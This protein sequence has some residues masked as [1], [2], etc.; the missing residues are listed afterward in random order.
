MFVAVVPAQ[1]A[2]KAIEELLGGDFVDR[3]MKIQRSESEVYVPLSSTVLPG[4]LVERY[5]IR[6]EEWDDRRRVVRKDPFEEICGTLEQQGLDGALIEL[7]PDRWEMHGDV[8][9]LKLHDALLGDRGR[10]AKVYADVL[11]ARTVLRDKVTIRG[12]ERVPEMELLLGESTE[13]IHC[14]NGILY[15]L[16]AARIMFSSGNIE[17]RMR[18][19][20]IECEGETVVDMFAGIGYL[21]LPMAVHG[22]PRT[23]FACEI[24]E[25]S[26][27][28]LVKNIALNHV[29]NIVM[30]VLGDNR[31]FDL[32]GKADRIIMGYLRDTYSFLPKAL[33][34][35]RSGG[36][37]HYHENYP[38]ALLPDGPAERL[39]STAGEAWNVEVIGQRVVKTFAPGVSHVV[40]DA[41]FTSSGLC[42][43][44]C[45][46]S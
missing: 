33:E 32:P 39:R 25:L 21:S 7:L 41:R 37:I 4:S 2:G 16:D 46:R 31:D 9:V 3:G 28:Y 13:G 26:Y 43:P 5:R 19:A 42:R 20:S 36:M 27:G 24:R 40:V 23:I 17:E 14:E 22:R 10:I 1:A 38:N 44:G 29:G 8:L 35:L 12:E 30:P 11:R 18:M 34:M 15:C 45:R 6:I